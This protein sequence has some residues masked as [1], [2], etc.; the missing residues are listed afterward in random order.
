MKTLN[1]VQGTDAW[2]AHRAENY[3]ASEAPAMMGKS[4]Y[5]SRDQLIHQQV[6]GE[7]KEIGDFLQKLFDKGHAAEAAI[8]PHVEKIVDEDLYPVTGTDVVDGVPLSASFDGLTIMENIVFEHKLWNEKLAANMRDG[9]VEPHYDYQIQQQLLISGAEKAIFVTSDGTPD[10]FEMIYVY[11]DKAIFKDLLS[12][13]KHFGD[14][15]A[16]YKPVIEAEKVVAEPVLGLPAVSIKVDGT[17]ALIDNLDVFGIALEEYVSKINKEP[18]TDQDFAN[19]EATVKTL[20]T[21]EDTLTA[22]ENSAL[23]QAESIDTMRRKVELF[24]SLARSNRL[25][26]EK[27]VKN[28]KA[29]RKYEIA[30]NA[31]KERLKHQADLNQK[32]GAH[33]IE[34]RGDFNAAMKGLKTITSI[35]SAANDE[36]ARCKILANEIFIVIE[37]NLKKI[38]EEYNF[39][40]NDLSM[41]AAK[42]TDDFALLVN[43]RINDHKDSEKAKLETER[44]KIRLEE[45]QKAQKTISDAAEAVKKAEKETE[46]KVEPAST[47]AP[48][49]ASVAAK[50]IPRKERDAN[51]DLIESEIK[52][53]LLDN[54]IGVMTA[55]KIVNLLATNSIKHVT[56]NY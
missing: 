16:N 45:E 2:H 27:L 24:R 53:S 30:S 46:V 33:Y 9:I 31:E 13:W 55:K 54:G 47:S 38:P 41:I 3:N 56:I 37:T 23:A 11:P 7:T 10:N 44:E 35:Q 51:I 34:V 39:L 20:K 25:T 29:A 22:S 36:L 40:F 50:P 26:T 5:M 32:L 17:I 49:A 43:S 18:K 4:K 12:G 28:E 19:L 42:Q 48:Q 52:T 1:L 8:R 6:T 21:A 15:M 14:D